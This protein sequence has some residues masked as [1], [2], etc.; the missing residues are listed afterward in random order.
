VS[1]PVVR[2]GIVSDVTP[3]IRLLDIEGTVGPVDFV[4]QTLF[5]Y[6]RRRIPAFLARPF[7]AGLRA[8]I[9]SLSIERQREAETGAPDGDAAYLLWLMD[10]DRKSGPLKTIQGRIWQ[11]GYESGDLVS[12]LFPDVLSAF[13]RWTLAGQTIAIFSSGSIL[14]QRLFF[15]YTRLGDLTPFI[16]AYFDTLTGPKRDPQSYRAIAVQ[17]DASPN[18]IQFL[19]DTVE[20]LDAA[21]R[22]GIHTVL[23]IRPGNRESPSEKPAA[24]TV[25]RNFDE[26]A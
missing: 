11:E 15:R 13:R 26:I 12:E 19:S 7:D 9:E 16:H 2:T 8:A 18:E 25:I 3:R 5:P 1:G 14:A 21:A 23:T 24:H 6:A 10:R 20:E 17:L 4:H 22:T